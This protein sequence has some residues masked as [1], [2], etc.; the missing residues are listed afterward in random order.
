MV[1][2][3]GFVVVPQADA[4]P[5]G[6]SLDRLDEVE[7]L[8]LAE[9]GDDVTL[10]PAT[11]AVVHAEFGVDGERRAL[12]GV[13]RAQADPPG[14]HPAQRQV[15]AGQSH[16]VRGRPHPG[17]VL[18]D[19]AHSRDLRHAGGELPLGLIARTEADQPWAITAWAAANRAM[20]TRN[21][22]HET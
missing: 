15:L 6:Q 9:E 18:F 21:G 20:G 2:A 8:H 16:E 10:G 5:G 13:E 17:D 7:V 14:A 3:G 1:P 4:G 19:Y 12:L 11:E 22:E